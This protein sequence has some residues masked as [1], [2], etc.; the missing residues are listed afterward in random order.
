MIESIIW[1]SPCDTG[2]Y[3][4]VNPCSS[5]KLPLFLGPFINIAE[6]Y[7]LPLCFWYIHP[8]FCESQ[9]N[10]PV[11][12]DEPESI[13]EIPPNLTPGFAVF[14]TTTFVPIDTADAVTFKKDDEPY[15]IISFVT[16]NEPLMIC[17]PTYVLEPV[18][19]Y[20]VS[21]VVNLFDCALSVVAID[22]LNAV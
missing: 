14:K 15:T 20:V 22:A 17:V 1:S 12:C 9:N 11:A 10:E 5:P 13:T 3:P 16:Y 21:I 8:F 4:A 18:V 19:A 2:T 6:W 7:E